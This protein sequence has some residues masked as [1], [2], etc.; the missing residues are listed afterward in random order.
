LILELFYTGSIS[1]FHNKIETFICISTFC[2]SN[3]T[4]FVSLEIK[5]RLL[6]LLK[7]ITLENHLINNSS[8]F[9]YL[10]FAPIVIVTL[11][12]LS[13]SRLKRDHL[14]IIESCTE[15]K[16][17]KCSEGA[18]LSFCQRGFPD[19]VFTQ[20]NGRETFDWFIF[21]FLAT[22]NE[23]E[24]KCNTGWL[25]CYCFFSCRDC[26]CLIEILKNVLWYKNYFVL[27]SFH[28]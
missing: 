27:S 24:H 19:T 26:I 2:H 13:V 21:L 7:I 6:L 9:I 1:L 17:L 11:L 28:Y 3:L 25:F 23:L 4:T 15:K 8:R 22:V 12:R 18:H 20:R 14:T 5:E 16:I 10:Y